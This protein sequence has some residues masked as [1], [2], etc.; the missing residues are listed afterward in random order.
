MKIDI[1][2]LSLEELKIKI[3]EFIL[4]IFLTTIVTTV[5]FFVLKFFGTAN[6]LISTVSISTSFCA[7]Y[8]TYRRSPFHAL[9]YATND[10]VLIV[11]WILASFEDISCLCVVFCFTAFLANDVYGFINW[12]RILRRQN[13]N[14]T[15]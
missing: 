5:F 6:L 3:K 11:L 1:A 2:S 10:I 15:E 9:A 13:K 7:V 12:N 8:L 14:L 4:L